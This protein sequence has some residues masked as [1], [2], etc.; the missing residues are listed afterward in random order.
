MVFD[1]ED[2]CVLVT[3]GQAASAAVAACVDGG[4]RR[5]G[6]VYW[7]VGGVGVA[8]DLVG[9]CFEDGVGLKESADRRVVD[10]CAEEV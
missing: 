7:V 1:L 3:A 8:A 5:V 4:S 9:I 6:G 2:W 10:P